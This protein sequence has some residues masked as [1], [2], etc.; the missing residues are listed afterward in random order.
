MVRLL[1][2]AV[3][4]PGRAVLVAAFLLPVIPLRAQSLGAQIRG[5]V[6]DA[7]GLP[8]SGARVTAFPADLAGDRRSVESVSG[9]D[10]SFT[11]DGLGAGAYQVCAEVSGSELLN[12]CR[13]DT[14]VNNISVAANQQ[15]SGVLVRLKKGL[16]LLVQV[17][18][19]RQLLTA[20]EKPGGGLYLM[21]GIWTTTGLFHPARMAGA[22]G[23][24][25]NYTLTV[26]VDTPIKLT[27]GGPKLVLS[28]EKGQ[29]V[30]AGAAPVAFQASAL[31]S[32]KVFR[33]RIDSV[34]N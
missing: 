15:M 12:P 6:L 27:V 21:I 29:P 2:L 16:P 1:M 25:R 31:D 14:R 10:G 23:P 9:Q 30:Q 24:G 28:D 5:Q 7:G 18:D 22:A 8:V 33:F 26:P 20:Y 13:W 11:L 17:D 3:G 4:W 32:Q 19:P 34:Q